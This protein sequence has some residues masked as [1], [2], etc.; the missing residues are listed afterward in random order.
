MLAVRLSQEL[1]EVA[2]HPQRATALWP[3]RAPK[4]A[5][6][7]RKGKVQGTLQRCRSL[8]FSRHLG[9]GSQPSTRTMTAEMGLPIFVA[10]FEV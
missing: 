9:L 1:V 10:R 7:K 6:A 8:E 4:T 2:V 5:N 3:P